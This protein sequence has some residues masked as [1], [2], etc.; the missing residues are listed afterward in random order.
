MKS[1]L[2]ASVL[3]F[4][5][6]ISMNSQS[7]MIDASEVVYGGSSVQVL[8][9]A[10]ITSSGSDGFWTNGTAFCAFAPDSSC[11]QDWSIDFADNI[12]N[13]FMTSMGVSSGDSVTVSAFLDGS[14]L[15]SQIVTTAA[16]FDFSSF[17][18]LDRIEFD[19]NSTAAGIGWQ[20]ITFD[21]VSDVPVPAPLALLILGLFGLGVTRRRV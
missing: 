21:V 12:S 5:A 8:S 1:I 7:A 20:N 2:Q 15:G 16:I 9:N 14:L 3:L 18:I 17:G 13:L 19:D 6:M 10:T 4:F 11:E